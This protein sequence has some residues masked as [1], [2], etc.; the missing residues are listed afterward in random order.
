MT[1]HC[2]LIGITT[3]GSF[4]AALDLLLIGIT[5]QESFGAA[6]DLLLENLHKDVLENKEINENFP[7]ETLGKISS[8][9]TPWFAD[10][11]NYHARNIIVKGMSSQQK[12]KFFKDVKQYFW[13]DPYLCKI[14]ANQIIR[15]CVH[16]QEANDI[17]KAC[18]E[19]PTGS[20]H[21]ANFTTKKVFD[22]DFFWP[23][24]YRDAHD[25]VTWC[26]ACQRQGKISQC[27]EMPQ[28]AIQVC[29]IFDV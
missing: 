2:S 22:A 10:F 13:D 9:S 16:G 27:E 20:H 17:F 24:I 1:Y 28:N 14:C 25:L 11:A 4:G 15:R 26:D 12:K 21:G 8:E 5:T 23:T 18:H 7:L 3:Q 19:G 6:L 29:K